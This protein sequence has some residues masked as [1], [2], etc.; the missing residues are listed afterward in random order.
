MRAIMVGPPGSGKGTQ[1]GLIQ[2]RLGISV[3]ATGD[4]FRERMKTDMALRDIVSSG[5][6]V[7][8][9]TTNR[10]VEDCLDKEDVSSGFVLDGYPRTLQQLDFLE[11]FLKRRALTL[12]AVFSLEVATDLLIERLR[13]R[14]KESGRTDDRDSVIARRLEIYTEMTLPIIDACEEKGLLHRIDASKGIEEVFQS[15][16]DVFD[17]VTI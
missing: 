14:S 17:R 11:G 7:S 6:Y 3:I 5:G 8:D 10:I 9:S 1:C 2:S 15:I 4:V 13:A 12:D 16:K